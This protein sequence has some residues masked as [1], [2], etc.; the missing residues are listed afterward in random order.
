MNHQDQ[1]RRLR[2]LAQAL[3]KGTSVDQ[4]EMNFLKESLWQ[5]GNGADANATLGLKSG[6]GQK[7]SDLVSRRRMSFILHTV[8]CFMFPD[9]YSN[10]QKMTLE[11]ACRKAKE[12]FVPIAKKLYPGAD[13]TRY[14]AAY[15]QRC[16]SSP[17]YKHMRS[18]L[19]R[20]ADDN[21]PYEEKIE[22]PK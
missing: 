10:E 7:V 22:D 1:R 21:S 11:D 3:D 20:L 14:T 13:R 5:I 12:E 18:P 4:L 16:H 2:R 19:R 8:E 6:R 17:E 15:I 9:P